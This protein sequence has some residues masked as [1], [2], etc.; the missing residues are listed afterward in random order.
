MQIESL[1]QQNREKLDLV[2]IDRLQDWIRQCKQQ[3]SLAMYHVEMD[4]KMLKINLESKP[5]F[6]NDVKYINRSNGQLRKNIKYF[7]QTY[8]VK[9]RE[10]HKYQN[11]I[12]FGYN[13][14]ISEMEADY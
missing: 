6:P 1:Q 5:Q 13:C 10:M 8:R 3:A 2:T 14:K 11:C 12:K 7:G 4:A 9:I